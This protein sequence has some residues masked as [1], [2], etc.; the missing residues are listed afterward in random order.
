MRYPEHTKYVKKILKNV[1][2]TESFK[3]KEKEVE[4]D[5]INRLNDTLWTFNSQYSK[6]LTKS[7]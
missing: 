7:F 6:I 4:R 2:E 5:R 1:N 3:K